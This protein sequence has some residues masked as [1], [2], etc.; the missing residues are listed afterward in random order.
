MPLVRRILFAKGARAF[1]DGFVSVLLP[2][3]L[4]ELGY[5]PLQ[6]GVIATATLLGS[7]VLTLAVGLRAHRF[8]YRTLLLGA[9]ALM[10]ATG[11]GFAYVTAFW[12]LLAIAVVGTLNPS[13]GDVSVFLP[14]EHA[15]LSR[16]ASDRQR[17]AVFARYSLVGSVAAAVGS[18]AAALP[19]L[20][21]APTGLTMREALQ[22]MFALYALLAVLAAAAYR[23]LP[24]THE[25]AGARR[26]APL[27]ESKRRVWTLAALF[28]LDAFGG[29]FVV[30]SMVALWLYQRFGLSL[31]S[32]GLFFFWTGLLSALSFLVAVRIA[33]RIGLVNTMVFTHLPANVCLVLVPFAPDLVWAIALLLVRAALSQMDVPTRSSY[34]MAIVLPAERPAAASVTSVP[35]S[36]AS[37][38]SPFLAGWLLTVSPFGWPLLVAGSVK[39][40]YDMLLLAFFRGVRPPEED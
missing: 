34:V 22:A 24:R 35:R 2:L 15:A 30:Q 32:A 21:T 33:G 16:L 23:G 18:A 3:Y 14:L 11:I 38:A 13:S 25:S 8:A 6:V 10:A 1:G 27:G 7:G 17:T 31:A 4:L 29:G 39:I 26:A 36:L 28:S 5:R 40:L 37:A 12:P 20:L 19:G 9:T